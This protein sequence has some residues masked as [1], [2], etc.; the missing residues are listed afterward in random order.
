MARGMAA[1]MVATLV[2]AA[3]IRAQGGGEANGFDVANVHFEPEARISESYDDRVVR[4][5]GG[6]AD[7]DTYTE[8]S[9]GFALRN[10]PARYDLSAH[11]RYGSRF[12][13]EYSDLNDDFYSLGASV[14]T[15]EAPLNGGVSADLAKTLN[16]NTAYDPASGNQPDS[17]LRD[18]P[19]RRFKAAASIAYDRQVTERLSV[20][21]GYQLTHY[22]QEFEQSGSAEWQIHT[23]SIRLNEHYSEKTRFFAGAGYSLQMNDDENG[24]IGQLSVGMEG[25]PTDKTSWLAE[26]GYAGADYEQ[27]G[28]DQGVVGSLRTFWQASEKVSAYLF[29][30][31][32]FQPGYD[33][34]S[35]RRVYRLGYGLE[36]NPLERITLRGSILHD[37][38]EDVGGGG[39]PDPAIGAVRHFF[40]TELSYAFAR[41]F[42][43]GI[44]YRYDK[45]EYDP[46]RQVVS[47]G[48]DWRY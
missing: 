26:V 2:P 24:T 1:L 43:A 48:M 31:S 16:Y 42:S 21:P 36:W 41:Q 47:V 17:I 33:G 32:D 40:D 12:Y 11:G 3:G 45:D 25:R 13:S 29:G 46:D 23:A 39:A 37:Y 22:Y 5:P 34:G 19:S 20:E 44:G 35:A 6:D 8:V 14:G 7:H 10:L 15:G 9:A 38:Q 27:S 4:L 28:T 18:E 30:S